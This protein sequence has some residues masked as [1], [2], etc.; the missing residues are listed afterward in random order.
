[1]SWCARFFL[2]G[3]WIFK[4]CGILHLEWAHCT[5][6]DRI[7]CIKILELEGSLEIPRPTW[8][9]SDRIKIQR[10]KAQTG[11]WMCCCQLR[12]VS[13]SWPCSACSAGRPASGWVGSWAGVGP[14]EG[15]LRVHLQLVVKQP[16]LEIEGGGSVW[17]D[18][19]SWPSALCAWL[20]G[21]LKIRMLR[22]LL[23]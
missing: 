22:I 4:L 19:I 5:W 20:R 7:Q 14:S 8:F 18:A 1:M 17:S 23:S 21:V 12:T 6:P 2:L 10:A 15:E 11:T 13:L 16:W 9:V 3:G